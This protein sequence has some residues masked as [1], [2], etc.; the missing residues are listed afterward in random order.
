MTSATLDLAKKLIACPSVTPDDAGCHD[1]MIQRLQAI[2]FTVEPLPFGEVNNF[3]ARRG[4]TAPLFVFAGHSDVVPPGPA[5]A[6][7]TPPFEPTIRNGLLYGRGAADMKGSLA[8]MVVACEAFIAHHPDH[9]G[10]IGFLITSDE[11]GPSINGTVKV[12]EHLSAHNIRIDACLVGEPTSTARVGDVIKNGRRGSL[13]GR[14]IVKGVQGHVAYPHLAVNPIHRAAPALAELAGIEWDRG[15]EFFPA[16]SF[17]ISNI[18]GGTGATNV[19]PGEVEVIFNFR[20]STETTH[21]QLKQRMTA[22]LDKHN[23]DY[24]LEWSLSG[25]PFLTAKGTLVDA[26][27]R[28]ILGVTGLT[29]EL[30]TS[31]GTSDGRFI[32]PTGAQVV[33]LGPVNA[34]IHK[35]N[36][37]VAVADLDLLTDIYR[38]ILENL[39]TADE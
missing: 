18:K 34:T 29:T 37:C 27:S 25:K 35:V 30:S 20:Y 10:S 9:R 1:L 22:I 3:W 39:L 6:W 4:D 17:Q 11:E 2:G 7:A 31:G 33:E 26:V 28:A 8:A 36:E 38:R 23:L 14:L 16:T 19:I 21:E 13:G 24:D 32:A 5:S 12:V 15:N